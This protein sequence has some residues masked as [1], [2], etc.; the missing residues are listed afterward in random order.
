MNVTLLRRR[1][2]MLGRF[3][4]CALFLVW[5]FF[6]ELPSEIGHVFR[7]RLWVSEVNGVRWCALCNRPF[8][9]GSLRHQRR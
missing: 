9:R 8:V 7:H 1:R 3:Y 5:A 2:T 6:V 4:I